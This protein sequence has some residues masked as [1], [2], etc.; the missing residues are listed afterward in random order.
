MT[1]SVTE[2]LSLLIFFDLG[3]LTYLDEEAVETLGLLE[4]EEDLL[5]E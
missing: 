1:L 2:V 4:N 5:L 3:I